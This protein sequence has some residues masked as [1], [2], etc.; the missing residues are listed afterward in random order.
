MYYNIPHEM[1]INLIDEESLP[2]AI[3]HNSGKM[4]I[5][6]L[7]ELDGVSHRGLPFSTKIIFESKLDRLLLSNNSSGISDTWKGGDVLIDEYFK[8]DNEYYG[9]ILLSRNINNIL[10]LVINTHFTSCGAE[11]IKAPAQGFPPTPR[12]IYTKIKPIPAAA[13]FEYIYNKLE[14]NYNE[15]TEDELHIVSL[16]MADTLGI[17]NTLTIVYF[18]P[19]FEKYF[20]MGVRVLNANHEATKYLLQSIFKCFSLKKKY[21]NNGTFSLLWKRIK[22]SPFFYRDDVVTLDSINEILNQL[23]TISKLQHEMPKSTYHI[24]ISEADFINGSLQKVHGYLNDFYN[25]RLIKFNYNN[26]I[27][28]SEDFGVPITEISST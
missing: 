23:Q 21:P 12:F 7:S 11:F 4:S 19:P 2:I 10:V 5:K 28:L 14:N 3:L 27:R 17:G 16:R 20:A 25:S 15:L 9:E 18:L 26:D 13:D 24:A 22:E 6:K 8:S 1:I